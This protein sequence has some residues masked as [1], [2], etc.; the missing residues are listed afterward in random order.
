MA[1]APHFFEHTI[2]RSQ[3]Q[4]TN[5]ANQ[6][7]MSTNNN[8]SSRASKDVLPKWLNSINK[9][10]SLPKI[11]GDKLNRMMSNLSDITAL[12][13]SNRECTQIIDLEG[14]SKLRRLDIS[15]NKLKRLAGMRSVADIGML[16]AS[17]NNLTGR[18]VGVYV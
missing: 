12:T 14:L 9:E 3:Q 15:G 7:A 17:K 18:W 10:Q 4:R 2:F 5:C 13:L 11:S 8:H 1:A 6:Q 16:N